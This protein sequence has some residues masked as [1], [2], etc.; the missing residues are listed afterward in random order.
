MTRISAALLLLWGL[1]SLQFAAAQSAAIAGTVRDA[2]TGRPLESAHVFIAQSLL[3]TVTDS[4]GDFLLSDVPPGWHR[5]VVSMLGYHQVVRDTLIRSGD[6]FQIDLRLTQRVI[7]MKGLT[8]SARQA[9]KWQRQLVKF[10][11]LFLGETPTAALTTITNPEVLSFAERWGVLTAS[12]EH[13]IEIENRALGYRVHYFL[14]EFERSGTTVKFDGDPLFEELE[15]SGDEEAAM[16]EANRRL[17]FDGSLRHFMLSLFEGRTE[18]EG[19]EIWRRRS[20]DR[21]DDS[22]Q[23]FGVDIARLLRSGPT[24]DEK[25]LDFSGFLEIIYHGETE[26]EAYSRW[27]GQPYGRRTGPQRS[28]LELNRGP[29]LIHRTGEVID[30]YGVVEYGYF[31]FE[32][33]ADDVPKKYLPSDW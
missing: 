18:E 7:E 2:G 30:P 3:G 10:K 33:I 20:L 8:V 4:D 28:W 17:A 29:T 23:R 6:D 19:F 1:H 13:A 31:A 27:I 32:R 24:P 12:A 25:E 14:K 11:R 15:A 16:W 26:D 9:R 21:R 22:M 5:L